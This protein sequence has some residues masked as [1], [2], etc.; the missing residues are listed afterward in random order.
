VNKIRTA[1]SVVAQYYEQRPKMFWRVGKELFP[2]LRQLK[3]D[4]NYYL[5]NPPTATTCDS[6]GDI[7]GAKIQLVEG[8]VLELTTEEREQDKA[9]IATL[10]A[11]LLA[12]RDLLSAQKEANQ[13]VFV[14]TFLKFKEETCGCRYAEYELQLTD[15]GG[16]WEGEAP[17]LKVVS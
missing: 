14:P 17:L 5:W 11:E 10:E 1:Q 13:Y 6:P 12:A 2:E 15:C 4:D 8:R 16:E 9:R 7:L 3:S